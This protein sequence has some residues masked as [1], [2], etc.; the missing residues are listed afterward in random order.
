MERLDKD[1]GRGDKEVIGGSQEK[2]GDLN[3]T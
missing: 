1:L 3:Q 2:Q